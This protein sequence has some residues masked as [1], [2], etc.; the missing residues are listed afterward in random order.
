M[1]LFDTISRFKI[2]SG[3]SEY[4]DYENNV[5]TLTAYISN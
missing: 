1:L 5:L 3:K 2:G 4:F